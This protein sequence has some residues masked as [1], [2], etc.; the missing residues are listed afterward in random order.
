[1]AFEVFNFPQEVFLLLVLENMGVEIVVLDCLRIVKIYAYKEGLVLRWIQVSI[2]ESLN[3]W[4]L[5]P[6]K[7]YHWLWQFL[8]STGKGLL[9]WPRL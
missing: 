7:S 1:V 9:G 3:I 4:V 8:L 2:S 6:L 5:R